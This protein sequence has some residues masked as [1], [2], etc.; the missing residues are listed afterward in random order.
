MRIIGYFPDTDLRCGWRGLTE[1]AKKKGFNAENLR[2]GE[3]LAFTNATG[4]SCKLL[5]VDDVVTYLPSNGEQLSI[6]DISGI[7]NYFAG[8]PMAI[9][10]NAKVKMRKDLNWPKTWQQK[11]RA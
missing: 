1:F 8:R 4:K 10:S 6:D 3:F 5:G 7:G 11:K 2:N 9:S